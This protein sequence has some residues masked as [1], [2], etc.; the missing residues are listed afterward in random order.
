[1]D[2]SL[3]NLKLLESS[4]LEFV[5]KS[6]FAVVSDKKIFQYFI[7]FCLRKLIRTN[8]ISNANYN[9]SCIFHGVPVEA[10]RSTR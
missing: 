5:S 2:Q 9:D 10:E 6:I 3:S 4:S 1:M 8:S 7:K